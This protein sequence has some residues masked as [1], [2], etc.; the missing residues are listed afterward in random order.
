M[1]VNVVDAVTDSESEVHGPPELVSESEAEGSPGLVQQ[2]S[3]HGETGSAGSSGSNI[4]VPRVTR[5]APPDTNSVGAMEIFAGSCRLSKSL[6]RQGFQAQSKDIQIDTAH[7]MSQD[8]AVVGAMHDATE[9]NTKYVHLSP[10]CNSFSR[11]RWPRVRLEMEKR[12]KAHCLLG[13]PGH[14][15]LFFG[16]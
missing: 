8:A 1:D 5:E 3:W 15:G 2:V 4:A 6:A 13:P 16:V 10:P 11:A 9:N 14:K 7:D 12:F